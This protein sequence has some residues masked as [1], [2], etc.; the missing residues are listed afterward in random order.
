[1]P[2]DDKDDLRSQLENAFSDVDD[3]LQSTPKDDAAD[4]S[5]DKP[6]DPAP[7]TAAPADKSDKP[8]PKSDD[9]SDDGK[10]KYSYR[11][12]P[13][14][15]SK[16]AKEEWARA[17]GALD[18][19]NPTHKQIGAL[20]DMMV[21]R[22]NETEADFEKRTAEVTEK[23]QKLE[24]VERVLSPYRAAIE[25]SGSTVEKELG[26]LL[27][28]NTFATTRP[29]DFVKWFVGARGLDPAKLFGA[30]TAAPSATPGAGTD[31]DDDPL[32]IIP[33]RYK[34]ALSAIPAL[35]AEIQRLQQGYQQVGTHL[36]TW[37]TQNWQ[38]QTSQAASYIDTWSKEADAGGN[39][40]RPHFANPTVKAE[41]QRLIESKVET[42]LTR[43]YDRAVWSIPEVR[44]QILDSQHAASVAE[45]ERAARENAARKRG[46]AVSIP[47]SGGN[48]APVVG[49]N[50]SEKSLREL[51][52]ANWDASSDT[53]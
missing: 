1:M 20:R 12:P 37:Q 36:Q 10:P 15:W 53:V 11:E 3:D 21:Q 14:R 45:R 5:D 40:L 34:Q 32:G 28:L 23:A 31:E 27:Q 52:M 2:D 16:E 19:A 7:K 35:Q 50:A 25:Q 13:S 8:A 39:L 48:V 51:L 30:A 26:D 4:K 44:Q 49:G 17:F 29:E 6:A 38:Q 43:A 9:K 42:D 18:P 47:A 24:A 22:A 41:I 46:A 33:P